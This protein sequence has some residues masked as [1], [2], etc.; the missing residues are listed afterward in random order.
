MSPIWIGRTLHYVNCLREEQI[1]VALAMQSTQEGQQV[2]L[3][4]ELTI[5]A[6]QAHSRLLILVEPEA[7]D[8]DPS[9]RQRSVTIYNLS[10]YSAALRLPDFV[11]D[12]EKE[13]NSSSASARL[14]AP[15][16]FFL[17]LEPHTGL[18]ALGQTLSD[19]RPNPAVA[20]RR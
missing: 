6:F 8:L 19:W 16:Q 17:S 14:L 1:G 18:A 13:L 10:P 12:M 20:R 7:Q 11:Q 9:A 5:P 15:S 3:N 4:K 2:D